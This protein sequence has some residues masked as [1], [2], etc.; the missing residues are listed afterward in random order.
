MVT[1]LILF[2]FFVMLGV[3]TLQDKDNVIFNGEFELPGTGRPGKSQ[4][5]QNG[6]PGW[7]SNYV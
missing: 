1:F 2:Y 7:V 5:Y 4:V 3:C 6:I